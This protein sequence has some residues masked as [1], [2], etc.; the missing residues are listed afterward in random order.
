MPISHHTLYKALGESRYAVAYEEKRFIYLSLSVSL[1]RAGG[2]RSE[3][4]VHDM[5]TLM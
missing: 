5:A 1:E 4:V 2:I 3:R